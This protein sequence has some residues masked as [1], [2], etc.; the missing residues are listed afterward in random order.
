MLYKS[1]TNG[2]II[3]LKF[4]LKNFII[5]FIIIISSSFLHTVE[6]HKNV[7]AT[8]QPDEMVSVEEKFSLFC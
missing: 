5:K 2:T 3:N 4:D 1:V 8:L 7:K 6:W